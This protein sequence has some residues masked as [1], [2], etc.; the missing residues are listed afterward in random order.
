MYGN[1]EIDILR[2]ENHEKHIDIG[3]KED[4]YK[5]IIKYIFK[6]FNV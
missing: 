6:H 2:I 5:N 4:Q 1:E 3:I